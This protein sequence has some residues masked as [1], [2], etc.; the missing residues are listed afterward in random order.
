M[1]PNKRHRP[2]RCPP[3]RIAD[4]SSLHQWEPRVRRDDRTDLSM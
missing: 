2:V 3:L 4:D 1:Y